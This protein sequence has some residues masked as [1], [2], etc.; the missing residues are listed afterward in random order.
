MTEPA[1]PQTP[2]QK[3]SPTEATPLSGEPPS[4]W[5]SRAVF[6]REV[7]AGLTTF[8][9][10]AYI[11][12]V[13]PSILAAAGMP[14]EALVT[15]TALAAALG[16]FLMAGLTNYPIA[17]APGMGTN[18]YFAFVVCIGMGLPWEV[19]LALT[20]WNSVLFLL[21]SVTGLRQHLVEALPLS[22]KLGIQG[23]IGFFIAFIGL[24]N[25][26]II[27]DNPATLVAAGD[28]TS[29]ASILVL[30]GLIVMLLLTLKKIP[31]NLLWGI[32][33]ITLLGLFIGAG[34]GQTVT[35]RPDGVFSLP[36]GIGETFFALDW[37]YP[38]THFTLVWEALLTLLILDLFDSV[39]TLVGLGRRARLMDA[40]GRMPRMS[41]A[42]S[43]DAVATMTGA[44]L[45]TSTT[46]SYVE[47]AA[48]I[49]SGGRTGLTAIVVGVC[50]LLALFLSPIILIIPP[51]ATAPALVMIGILM[52]QGL[53]FLD[54]DDLTQ[55][56]PAFITLFMIPLTFSITEGIALG[57]LTYVLLMLVS[58]RA[59]EVHPLS[60]VIGA[61]FLLYYA[62]V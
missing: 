16:C 2:S 5:F 27:T 45:G 22:V 38:L 57:L 47:S 14:R 1:S 55:V 39:G 59:K 19:A 48:G 25:V 30:V 42:L 33:L 53:K 61:I 31:G 44:L 13:N 8:S 10:M 36:N 17:L 58:G 40:Q 4:A 15:V 21:L 37:L 56:A 32:L 60:Y 43:A 54:F 12:A 7:I 11:L 34:E 24:K 51:A 3:P 50:F 23:G 62:A 35:A 41:R 26:G 9:A 29:A 52:L 28:L 20:F 46:T 49:E 6:R 18:A